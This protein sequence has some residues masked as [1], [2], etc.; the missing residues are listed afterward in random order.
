MWLIVGLGNPGPQYE[1][2]RHNIGFLVV[3]RLVEETGAHPLSSS[4]FHGDLFK[5]SDTLFLKPTTYMN[6]SGVSVQ[7]V[8]N[9]YKI[10]LEKVIV[11]HDDLDLP[12]G[13]V[14][15]KKGGG[16]GGHNGLKSIDATVGSDYLRVRMGIGKP[17]YKSQ[18]VDYVLHDFAPEEMAVLPRWIDHAAKAT[19]ELTRHPLD[20]VASRFGVKKPNWSAP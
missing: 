7:A 13:A 15:F 9:F 19:L 14:R 8:K 17:A 10:E 5:K 20:K 18:V 4:S 1:R 2:T 11:V 16:S 12:F 6:R 3:D